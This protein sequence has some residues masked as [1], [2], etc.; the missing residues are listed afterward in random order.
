[1]CFRSEKRARELQA[2]LCHTN[3]FKSNQIRRTSLYLA[4]FRTAATTAVVCQLSEA[5]RDAE[6]ALSQSDCGI[7][8]RGRA[9]M[10]LRARWVLGLLR[11]WGIVGLGC[12]WPTRSFTFV[13]LY[14]GLRIQLNNLLICKAKLFLN[15][16]LGNS[17]NIEPWYWK[18]GLGM[19]ICL[20]I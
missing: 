15:C 13:I 3:S 14:K 1:M 18:N 10:S 12:R 20:L 2:Y 8:C 4:S 6:A 16:F 5:R 19:K 11:Q 7:N 17:K 9:V